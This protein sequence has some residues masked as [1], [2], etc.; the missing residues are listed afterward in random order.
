[1]STDNETAHTMQEN[2]KKLPDIL[3][4]SNYYYY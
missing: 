1:M 4:N 3:K 2:I